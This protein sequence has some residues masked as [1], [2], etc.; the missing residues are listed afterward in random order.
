MG[1]LSDVVGGITGKTAARAAERAAGVQSEAARNAMEAQ[2]RYM[3][4]YY[5]SGLQAQNRLMT[6]LGLGG[7]QSSADYGMFNR[8]F[9]MQ[10]FQEDPGYAFRMEQGTKA[11]NR[12]AAAKGGMLSGNALRALTEYGQNLASQEYQN[13]YNR[14]M[15]QRRFLLNPLENLS[16]SGRSAAGNLSNIYGQGLTDIGTAQ[17][18]GL[19]GA[20]N[21]RQAGMQNMLNLGLMAAGGPL[22]SAIG[23]GL[24]AVGEGLGSIF[25]PRL[26]SETSQYDK[27]VPFTGV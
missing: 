21:A 1:F 5:Q 13:A 6:L 7:D 14:F 17:A 16:G 24:S 23:G 19:M 10:D 25:G 2:A 18:S 27:P 4:P 9:G 11:L 12:G 22:A 15:D 20:A 26:Y 8:Q 3:E